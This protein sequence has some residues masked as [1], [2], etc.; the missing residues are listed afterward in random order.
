MQPLSV[1][2]PDLNALIERFN[3]ESYWVATEICV[4]G[5]VW[6]WLTCT[7]QFEISAW[8]VYI[9][10]VSGCRV[11]VVSMSRKDGY[12]VGS[13]PLSRFF[14]IG[15]IPQTLPIVSFPC[16]SRCPPDDSK[17]QARAIT[18]FVGI[19]MHCLRL[20]NFYCAFS[21]MGY[22]WARVGVNGS[23]GLVTA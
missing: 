9:R 21:L 11:I 6:C 16:P 12:I 10:L 2:S 22:A 8:I 5:G 15:S 14:A 7:A 19:A 18:K 13:G 3:F 4:L 20:S 1:H 23:L 17:A